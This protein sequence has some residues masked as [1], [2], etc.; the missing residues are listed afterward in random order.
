M[1]EGFDAIVILE[2]LNDRHIAYC[3][4]VQHNTLAK[5]YGAFFFYVVC[6]C[7][8]VTQNRCDTLVLIHQPEKWY[9]V[10]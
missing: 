4:R 7:T 9:K 8:R 10:N 5:P 2:I 1:R 6:F 3:N